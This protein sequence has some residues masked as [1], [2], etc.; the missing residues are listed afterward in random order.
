AMGTRRRHRRRGDRQPEHHRRTRDRQPRVDA[1]ARQGQSDCASV[2]PGTGRR[3]GDHRRHHRR[4]EP[5]GRLPVTFP[6][7]LEQTPRPELPG[8]G[9]PWGTPVTIEYN[10]GA[11]IGYRW[12]AKTGATPMYAFGH[13]LSYTTFEYSGLEVTGGETVTATFTVTNTGDRPGADVPQL[14]LTEAAGE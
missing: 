12:F 6:E 5:S 13:G 11:E 4:S 8:L 3:S 2:V 9:T 10:E 14:Y 7:S 1:L